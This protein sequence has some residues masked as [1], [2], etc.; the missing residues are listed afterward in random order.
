MNKMKI[1]GYL[2]LLIAL[3]IFN[4]CSLES[5]DE[6]EEKQDI[7]MINATLLVE[8]FFQK[9][10]KEEG[11]SSARTSEEISSQ[12]YCLTVLQ[13]WK[14]FS[15]IPGKLFF[16]TNNDHVWFYQEVNE[17]TVTA[18]VKPG[19]YVFWYAGSGLKQV[20]G[21]DFDAQAQEIL[22]NLPFEYEQDQMWYLKVPETHDGTVLKYDI[23]YQV[24]GE[25]TIIRL[26]PKLKV[27]N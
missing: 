11:H 10:Q 9:L 8:D 12:E 4:S 5:E 3:L 22:D 14:G 2:Y 19:Q 25:N 18:E 20:E 1:R 16:D 27:N 26:D 6:L 7:D 15:G 13:Y 21:I 17:Q 24:E 23:V